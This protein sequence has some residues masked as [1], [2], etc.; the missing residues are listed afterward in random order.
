MASSL[1]SASTSSQ[2]PRRRNLRTFC[3][4]NAHNKGKLPIPPINPK[5]PFGS[6]VMVNTH[7]LPLGIILGK[8][9]RKLIGGDW[10]GS[11]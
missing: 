3:A 5:D 7:V 9:F 6:L 1:P 2:A 11:L 10:F 8:S 4:I